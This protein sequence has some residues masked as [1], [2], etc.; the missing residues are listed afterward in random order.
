M[1]RR[2]IGPGGGGAPPRSA[3]IVSD[4]LGDFL[5]DF[6]GEVPGSVTRGGEA[7]TSMPDSAPRLRY[8]LPEV[9]PSS[10]GWAKIGRSKEKDLLSNGASKAVSESSEPLWLQFDDELVEPLPP[11]NVVSETAY[12]LFYKRRRM[13]PSNIAKYSTLLFNECNN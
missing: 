7:S 10:S 2:R 5:G 3:P 12:V 9:E 11:Q 4:A 6:L 1:T 13:R 8:S